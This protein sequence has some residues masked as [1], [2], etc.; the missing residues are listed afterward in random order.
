MTKEAWL[1]HAAVPALLFLTALALVHGLNLDFRMA[2]YFF[3]PALGGFPLRESFWTE[4]VLHKGGVKL[5]AAAAALA[6]LTL[7]AGPFVP[8]FRS[9]RRGAAYLLLCFALAPGLVALGKKFSNVDC[10]WSLERYG[11]AQPYVGLVEDRPDELP[12]AQ[13]FP[14]GHSSGAFAFF[15]LYF[16]LRASRPRAAR[17]ALAATL[18]LGTIFAATQWARGAHFISHDLW[19]AWLAWN[20]CLLLSGLCRPPVLNEGRA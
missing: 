3:D 2:D 12:P 11:G 16:L 5:P 20:V 10:P 17:H 8:R 14:A 19:S 13:C 4:T 1:W 7:L 6:L 9:W 18:L 15:G